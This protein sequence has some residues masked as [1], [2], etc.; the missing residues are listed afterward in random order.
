MYYQGEGAPKNDAESLKWFRMTAENGIDEAQYFGGIKYIFGDVL[1][2]YVQ[3][4]CLD[5]L[6]SG[7]RPIGLTRRDGI[8]LC[9]RD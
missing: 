7:N 9:N 2:N 3:V 1:T 8:V 6:R 5:G 4:S